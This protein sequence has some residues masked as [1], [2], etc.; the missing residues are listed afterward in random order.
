MGYPELL[1]LGT[2][3]DTACGVIN[4][5]GERIRA[6][7]N[8]VPGE[9]LTFPNWPHRITVEEVPNPGDIAF[10]ANR[11]YQRPSEI[12]VPLLKLTYDD[13]AGRFPWEEEHAI[14]AWVQPRPGALTA[15][16]RSLS[17]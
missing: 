2:S 10:A 6:G 17:A 14:P 4:D 15:R 9:L 12:S 7:A 8:L 3:I 1:I 11:H 13:K 16:P 5:L